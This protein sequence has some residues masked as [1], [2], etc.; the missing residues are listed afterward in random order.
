MKKFTIIREIIVNLMTNQ[1]VPTNPKIVH[2]TSKVFLRRMIEVEA[3]DTQ[4]HS[5]QE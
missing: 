2:L 1:K 4:G 3:V 5:I